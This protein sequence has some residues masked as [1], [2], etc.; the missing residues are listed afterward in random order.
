MSRNMIE[1]YARLFG[2]LETFADRRGQQIARSGSG[3]W[4]RADDED[5]RELLKALQL[6]KTLRFG[7]QRALVWAQDAGNDY[8]LILGFALEPDLPQLEAI[9]ANSGFTMAVLAELLP[10][11]VLGAAHVRNV[12]EVGSKEDRDYEGHDPRVIES[13]FPTIQAFA[14]RHPLDPEVV[15]RLFL[16]LSVAE[17]R[18]SGSWIADELADGLESL[19]DLSVPSLPYGSLCESIFDADPRTMF[20]AIYRCI[21]ATYAYEAT[22]KLVDR[23]S[24][25]HAWSDVAA[26]LDEEIGWHPRE[27]QALNLVLKHALERDLVNVCKCLDVEVGNDLQAAAGK[28]IYAVRNRIV[29]YRPGMAAPK[30]EYNWNELCSVMVHIVFHVFT[31]AYAP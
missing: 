16:R 1:A 13:L 10:M 3:R 28:A 7:E 11:P 9:S 21:E 8:V 22:R 6:R 12:V 20:L 26:A 27:A 24:L 14:S 4:A 2:H 19:T 18:A 25:P 15:A 5:A 29:H 31:R 30:D 17:C 23:L